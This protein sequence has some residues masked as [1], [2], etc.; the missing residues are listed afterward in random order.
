MNRRGDVREVLLQSESVNT[1]AG[2]PDLKSRA[3]RS[4][5]EAMDL[6]KPSIDRERVLSRAG[7]RRKSPAL[8]ESTKEPT[9]AI[10]MTIDTA[11]YGWNPEVKLIDST[12]SALASRTTPPIVS[13][14]ISGL[15]KP[16]GLDKMDTDT[17]QAVIMDDLLYV[18]VGSE[19]QYIRFHERYNPTIETDRLAGPEF[20][21]ARGL[22]PSLRDL[23]KI[24]LKLAT[25]HSSVKAFVELRSRT[26]FGVVNHA[27]CAAMRTILDEYL[28]VM[29]EME[30]KMLKEPSFTLNRFHIETM[31]LLRKLTELSHIIQQV[32]HYE[33]PKTDFYE[34]AVTDF[35]KIMETLK[36]NDGNL[37]A[38]NNL[39]GSK[40]TSTITK[41]GD[42][43]KILTDRL[44]SVCGDPIARELSTFLLEQASKPY[45]KMLNLW[46]HKGVIQDPFN[47]F[48]IKEQKSIRRDKIDEDYTDE[49]WEKRYLVRKEAVPPQ[50]ADP[51]ICDKILLAGKFLNVVRECGGV[52]ASSEVKDAP[53]TIDD[54]GL[55]ANIDAAY[56]H[57]NECLLSLLINAHKLAD[58]L[59]S[60]KHYFFLD[61]ADFFTNFLDVANHELKKSAKNVSVSKLQSLLDITIRQPG[62]ITATDPFKEDITVQLNEVGLTEWLMRIVSVSGLD[63]NDLVNMKMFNTSTSAN[64]KDE[65]KIITGIQAL[66]F[67]FMV[68]FPLS[69][70]VSRK[71]ILRYQLLFRH[72]V[73]LKHIEQLLGTGWLEQAKAIGWRLRSRHEKLQKYK[74]KAINLRARMLV[75]IQQVLY[76]STTEVIEP[77]WGT[78]M[79]SI[80]SIDTVD[81][82]MQ[83]HVDFLDT[84][85]KE[86]MLTNSKL[87]RVMAKLMAACKMFGTYIGQLSKALPAIDS[88]GISQEEVQAKITKLESILQ[89]Y[90][91][92]FDHH[93]KILMDALNYYA[94]TETVVL[95]SLC[96]RLE[97]CI[98]I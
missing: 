2:N 41:G 79:N 4:N 62:S 48:L 55:L 91:Q 16:L 29:S 10:S 65:K 60:M 89:Q 84:C 20:R 92:N 23:T 21:L 83:G 86:C 39:G 95:L 59:T 14:Q 27:L 93:L 26:E 77:R 31:P 35:D 45:M 3:Q 82:L 56:R 47:E 67:D 73:A 25:Y 12:L 51:Q 69:L 17:Q 38:L 46:L 32:S 57:A 7:S 76:F 53:V 44:Y 97:V 74:S 24:I 54:D 13:Y 78:L 36:A 1:I 94:A 28:L 5:H 11:K 15:K 18:L 66:Q 63:P 71:T 85:L 9:E 80:Q 22:D 88:D 33:E 81:A 42:V 61:Q 75:F 43:I 6:K 37:H 40:Q 49:Y 58:R 19:G 64:E 8:P 98:N 96:A 90:E 87:L 34:D 50:I 70:V 68:P 72:L 30:Y 52:D